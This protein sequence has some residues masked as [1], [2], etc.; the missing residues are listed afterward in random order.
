MVNFWTDIFGSKLPTVI[1]CEKAIDGLIA[2]PGYF[3]SNLA[4]ILVGIFLLTKKDK[5]AKILGIISILIGVLSGVYDASFKFNSQILDLSGMFLLVI[6]LLVF[7]LY[8]LKITSSRNS[9]ILAVVLQILSMLGIILLEAQSGR[10]LFGLYVIGVIITELIFWKRKLLRE[11][12][13]FA[14][15]LG[16][17]LLGF[18]IWMLDS[19]QILCS[20][21]TLINGRAVFH[22]LTAISI[23]YLY[24]YNLQKINSI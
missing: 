3:I 7:N 12:K 18:V 11:Y 16:L 14:I 6:F 10:I 17:F 15:A 1:Y 24:K 9:I 13:T 4:Y 2:R 21:I 19:N 23:Y 22:Y 20:P 5:L 8:K